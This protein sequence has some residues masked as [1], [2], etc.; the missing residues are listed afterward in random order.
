MTVK[1]AM[2]GLGRW[3]MFLGAALMETEGVEL[4]GG[5]DSSLQSAENFAE[6]FEV[7]AVADLAAIAGDPEVDAVVVATANHTHHQVVKT[8][9]QAGK[10][11]FVE[12]PLANSLAE[13]RELI[14][15][16]R[17]RKRVLMVGH[18]SRRYPAVRKLKELIDAGKIGQVHSA[19]AIFSYENLA[20][21]STDTWRNDPAKCPGGPLMQLAV[22]QADNLLWLLGPVESVSCQLMAPVPGG[23]VPA[24]GR[25][26]L[27][28]ASGA[29]GVLESDYLTTPESFSI[30]LRGEKGE[31]QSRGPGHVKIWD[32]SGQVESLD[33]GRDD[34]LRQQMAEFVACVRDRVPPETGGEVGIAAL[35]LIVAGL[36]SAELG[37]PVEVGGYDD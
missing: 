26:G 28:F 24:G 10:D 29:L 30:T 20:D 13:C 35:A 17:E 19:T 27:K 34:S 23:K 3:A 7:P 22:H 25:L 8:L 33:L 11:V 2:V 37:R 12:K 6:M 36:E 5:Y 18:N 9:L 15:L 4:T 21:I 1:I 14:D 31:F 32:S 16:A